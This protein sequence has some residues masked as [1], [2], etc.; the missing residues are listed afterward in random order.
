MKVVVKPGKYVLAVSGG[1][2]SVTLL[3]MLSKMNNVLL[4][5]A[6]YDHGIR[7]ESHK[8][9]IFVKKLAAQYGYPFESTEGKL[10][11]NASEA[12]A[13]EARYKF[14]H[15]VKIKHGA[16]AIITAHHQD[17]VV[18]TL[19]MNLLR[20]TRRKGLSSLQSNDEVVRPMLNLTKTKIIAYA[21]RH[22][23]QWR[24]DE[25]NRDESYTR[26]WIRHRVLPQLSAAQKTMLLTAHNKHTITN[27]YIDKLLDSFIDST[28]PQI[29]KKQLILALPHT[30]AIELIAH[31]LRGNSMRE[32]ET[33]MLER[34]TVDVKTLGVGKKVVLKKGA[35]IIIGRD[36]IVLQKQVLY[37]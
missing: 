22:T 16:D 35:C 2:D 11:S 3:N 24:E 21:K 10:G 6:H 30:L 37:K 34:I 7:A 32:F 33:K 4:I 20:G 9:R 31:W 8:D 5:I 28:H 13:R 26:N 29:L 18:E 15:D 23:L 1:V 17:D 19:V 12:T 25:T 14:L 27:L 36:A